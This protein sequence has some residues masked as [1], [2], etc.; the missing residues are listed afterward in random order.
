MHFLGRSSSRAGGFI[1]FDE[2]EEFV[3]VVRRLPADLF[4]GEAAQSGNLAGHLF[5]I[6][7]FVAL[8]T[9]WDG[10]QVGRVRFDQHSVERNDRSGIANVLGLGEGYVSC[11]RNHESQIQTAPGV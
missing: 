3:K 4:G 9:V 5:D 2:F 8:T 7:R 10:S 1:L 6:S 11:E